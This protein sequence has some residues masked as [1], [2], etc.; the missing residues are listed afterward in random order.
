MLDTV[1]GAVRLS[2]ISNCTFECD[3]YY[4]YYYYYYNNNKAKHDYS[5]ER[6]GCKDMLDA[7]SGRLYPSRVRRVDDDIFRATLT[8]ASFVRNQVATHKDGMD[9]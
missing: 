8:F 9:H 3:Y 1:C 6:G 2:K 7:S 5:L 4:Y